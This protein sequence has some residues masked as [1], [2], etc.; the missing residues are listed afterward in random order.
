M[1]L[2]TFISLD[3]K[4]DVTHPSYSLFRALFSH[5]NCY[6]SHYPY[7]FH[8]KPK[9]LPSKLV[10]TIFIT[11]LTLNLINLSFFH[12]FA[13]LFVLLFQLLIFTNILLFFY[14]KHP[15]NS[16]YYNMTTQN[17]YFLSWFSLVWLNLISPYFAET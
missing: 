10:R 14:F 6:I 7:V 1:L 2:G 13:V 15:I 12:F 3:L 9:C 4:T 16:L 11:A 8:P 5:M 17:V